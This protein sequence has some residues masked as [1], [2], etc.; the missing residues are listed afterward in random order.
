MS[1][2]FPSI[3]III[4]W[5]P[6][7][8]TL[9]IDNIYSI[10]GIGNQQAPFDAVRSIRIVL[11]TP[12]PLKCRRVTVMRTREESLG[13]PNK[14]SCCY[15]F[16]HWKQRRYHQGGYIGGKKNP[17]NAVV[18]PGKSTFLCNSKMAG[19]LQIKVSH[20]E[21]VNMYFVNC[22]TRTNDFITKQGIISVD[23][24]F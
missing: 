13:G 15:V 2:P 17:K 12:A 21:L 16:R 8:V 1:V 24:K 19:L 23:L 3:R 9:A 18:F 22:G 7:G 10:P 6:W 11:L 4:L 14:T 5:I 20:V